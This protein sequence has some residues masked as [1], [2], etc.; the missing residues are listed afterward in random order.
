MIVATVAVGTAL[1]EADLVVCAFQRAGGD[2]LV[3]RVQQADAMSAQ[4]VAH[5]AEDTDTG[6]FGALAPAVEEVCRSGLGILLPKLTQ[7]V[8][9]YSTPE[10]KV[11]SA[12]APRPSVSVIDTSRLLRVLRIL[13]EQP[14]HAPEHI[15]LL[16]DF[17]FAVHLASQRGQLL[18]YQL[19]DVEAVEDQLCRPE[20]FQHGRDV[21]TA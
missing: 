9:E 6:A 19:R 13:D 8:L 20:M 1:E 4:R 18:V 10:P 7:L 12:S 14:A 21:A 16:Y 5:G 11:H 3:V 2:Q 17:E 15:A